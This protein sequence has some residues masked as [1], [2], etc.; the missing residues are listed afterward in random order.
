MSTTENWFQRQKR[1][2]GNYSFKGMKSMPGMEG[3]AWQGM[4]CLNGKPIGEVRD[5]GNGGPLWTNIDP[6]FV[7]QLNQD[8][9]NYYEATHSKQSKE[10]MAAAFKYVSPEEYFLPFLADSQESQNKIAAKCKKAI[11]A[12]PA[13]A[14]DG[15]YVAWKVGSIVHIDSIKAKNPTHFFLN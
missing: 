9:V 3:A 6:E 13:D 7:L 10:A 12:I 4:L 5:Y 8:S 15:E 1:L 2:M 14:K 11:C